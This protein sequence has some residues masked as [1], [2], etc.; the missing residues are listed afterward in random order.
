MSQNPMAGGSR[1]M[2]GDAGGWV[3]VLVFVS[4]VLLLESATWLFFSF[5]FLFSLSPSSSSFPCSSLCVCGFLASSFHY[6]YHRHFVVLPK[7]KRTIF[8]P[9]FF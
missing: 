5:S 9:F 1:R 6:Y 3:E 4:L 8:F 7:G 2:P